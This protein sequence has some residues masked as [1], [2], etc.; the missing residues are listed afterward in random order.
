M[1]NTKYKFGISPAPLTA[2]ETSGA[3][4]SII[5]TSGAPLT[6]IET[7]GA[8]Q[9]IISGFEKKSLQQFFKIS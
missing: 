1:T 3:L 9:S 7:S 8:L 4:Q 6:A 5:E 2:T